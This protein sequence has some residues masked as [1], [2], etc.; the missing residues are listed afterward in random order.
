MYGYSANRKLR[1]EVPPKEKAWG[2]PRIQASLNHC[3]HWTIMVRLPT[4]VTRQVDLRFSFLTEINETGTVDRWDSPLLRHWFKA[5][6]SRSDFLPRPQRL[7]NREFISKLTRPVIRAVPQPLRL[8][9]SPATFAGDYRN[10]SG[11]RKTGLCA[12]AIARQSTAERAGANRRACGRPRPA[13]FYKLPAG[14][15]GAA[16]NR[17]LRA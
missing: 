4:E 1:V 3:H 13:R 9:S 7:R 5:K 8:R 12:T 17:S 10:R 16:N 14:A 11:R 15:T 6:N 2:F